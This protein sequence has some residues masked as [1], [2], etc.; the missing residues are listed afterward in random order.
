MRLFAGSKFADMAARAADGAS[1][2][3]ED[4]DLFYFRQLAISLKVGDGCTN[5]ALN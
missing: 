3:I 4:L 5:K 1:D 2:A